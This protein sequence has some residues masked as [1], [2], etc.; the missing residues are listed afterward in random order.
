M[1]TPKRYVEVLIFGTC[2]YDPICRC[3]QIK[4]KSHWIG[5]DLDATT[6]VLIKRGTF[7]YRDTKTDRETAM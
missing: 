2:E 5:V 7:K 4:M 1:C 6:G 3:N